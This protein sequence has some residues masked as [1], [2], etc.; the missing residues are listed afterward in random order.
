M[1]PVPATED[2]VCKYAAH[3]AERLKPNSVRQYLNIIRILHLDSGYKNPSEDSWMLKCTL[4]G[5]D[6]LKGNEVTRKE[7]ITP[8]ILIDLKGVLNMNEL[9]D[10][11]FWAACL[12]LFFGTFR[13]S[14]LFPTTPS[15]FTNEK[16]FSRKDF[17]V[18]PNGSISLLVRWSK[19]IQCKERS[20]M[21]KLPK[22]CHPLSPAD[23]VLNAFQCVKLS[24]C[25]P[26]IVCDVKG[27]PMTCK[28]FIALLKSKLAKC[29]YDTTQFSS[30]SFRRGSAMW[31]L[32]CGAPTEVVKYM[33]D[34]KSSA[35]LA[36]LDSVPRQM[37]EN[38]SEIMCSKLP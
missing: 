34:W 9:K 24:E 10:C 2:I 11:M 32:R 36:Y 5:I 26:S 23:A 33:G 35:Y 19:T 30:H 22:L 38:Y 16:Q 14:N 37:Y 12:I 20:Y 29:G 25:S 21:V 28:Q 27:T 3:L 18:L 1:A 8:E 15:E 17:V 13:K 6:R 7:P 4:R 31:A